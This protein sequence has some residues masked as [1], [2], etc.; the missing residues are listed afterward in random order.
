MKTDSLLKTQ[1][2]LNNKCETELI[3]FLSKEKDF[4][5]ESVLR[6]KK[7]FQGYDVNNLEQCINRLK[8][9]KFDSLIALWLESIVKLSIGKNNGKEKK[10]KKSRH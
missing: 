1:K 10:H 2:L 3:K 5:D 8:G 7:A 4:N 6:F 9:I